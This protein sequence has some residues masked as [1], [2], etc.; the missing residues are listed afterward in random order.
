LGH[1]TIT[2]AN[3]KGQI[4]HTATVSDVSTHSSNYNNPIDAKTLSETTTRYDGRGRPIYQ[5]TWLTPR[6]IVDTANPPIAGL[7][8]VALA[9]GLTTQYLYDDNLFDGVGLD[10][11]LGLSAPK[12]GTGGTGTTNISLSAAISKLSSSQASGGA[13]VTF[14]ATAPGRATV[15]IS[16]EDEISFS[17]SDAAG[18]TVMTG[19]LNNYKGTGPTAANTLATWSCTLHDATQSLTGYGT[20][21]ETRSIDALGFATRTWTDA[22]GRTMRSLDQLD[23]A[24]A[25][26]YDAGGNQLS[27]RDPNSVGA[28]MLYDALGR[29][30]QR[31]D[32]FGDVTKTDYDRAGNAIKQTDA[33]NKFTLISFDARNRR[34]STSDRISAA[35]TF[36][37]LPT[38]QLASLTD[39]EN[40]VTSYTYDA[41]GSKL[42]EQYPD[43][44]NGAALGTTGYGIVTFVYDAGNRL[45]QKQDQKGD[46]IVFNYDLV[47]RVVTRIGSNAANVQLGS[48]AFVYN[49][50]GRILRAKS[51][52]SGVPFPSVDVL[53]AYDLIGRKT[54][55]FLTVGKL[56]ETTI[57]YNSRNEITQLTYPD[58]SVAT[59]SYHPTGSL[60]QLS[61]DG[62][63]V[64]TRSYDDGNRQTTE[65]LGNGI[66]ESRNYRTDNLLSNISYS[67]TS[68]G[69]LSYSWDANKNKTA[70]AIDGIMSGYSF[71]ASGTTYDF[72]DRLTAFARGN[73]TMTQ[74]WNLSQVGD[75]NSVT[76]NG[77]TQARTHGP[78]HELLTAG[79]SS[80]TSD[81]NGNMTSIPTS[82]REPGP[83][84]ALNLTWDFENRLTSADTDANGTADVR[85]RYDALGRRVARIEGST[86]LIFVHVD[87]QTIA[88]YL[89][90]QP[91][92]SPLYRYVYASYVDEPVLRK[93]VGTGGTVLYYHRNQQYSIYALSDS[94]GSVTERYAYTAYGQPTFLN[95]SA[96]VQTSS[97]ANNRYTYTARE[98]DASIGLYHFRARWMSGL[99]G[100]F[101]S[102]DP[103]GY[104]RSNW[105]QYAYCSAK[106]INRV[107]PSG[108]LDLWWEHYYSGNGE[109][110]NINDNQHIHQRLT[111]SPLTQGLLDQAA[112]AAMA[113]LSGKP[114]GSSGKLNKE[115]PGISANYGSGG[116]GYPGTCVYGLGEWICNSNITGVATLYALGNTTVVP[117]VSC[118][119]SVNCSKVSFKTCHVPLERQ[120]RCVTMNC[121]IRL[122]Y[123]DAFK[124]PYDPLNTGIGFL[125]SESGKK[126]KIVGSVDGERSKEACTYN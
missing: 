39:A 47:G 30:T 40:Q 28:D 54:I 68:I 69:N 15:T 55:E 115:L 65:V 25:F 89:S 26:T 42:T 87:Q 13:G 104:A 120:K 92:S 110:F 71:N 50:S 79:T 88:D 96:A 3:S 63:T 101:C 66:T 81:V 11:S 14:T 51:N 22:A 76:T 118:S 116:Y 48:E 82:L 17:I 41:R 60:N 45:V 103:I 84:S 4:V 21:L 44:V 126:Y 24:T 43:H 112:D 53:F 29:N 10:N 5:T 85:Y 106:P 114:C 124:E 37:Y 117:T 73:G 19:K 58:G 7:N 125:Q 33:K 59:R 91:V 6:G 86:A 62:S 8:G 2:N 20:V 74:S 102:R 95:A 97:A 93:T 67:N 105:S 12:L 61:L 9:D 80:V 49:R 108:L 109:T 38:G 27:V 122:S 83:T 32:T 119:Y 70:E 75:W 72:E 77:T 123:D 121:D 64:S 113:S 100:R 34:K 46:K 78:T 57:S 23:K 35:T 16:P 31:T 52:R 107:D 99:T 36:T 111:N 1:G 94:S 56:F 90:V 98:W 18:R